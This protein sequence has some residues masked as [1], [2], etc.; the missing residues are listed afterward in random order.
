[1]KILEEIKRTITDHRSELVQKYRVK[2]IGIFGS[3]IR[4]EQNPKSDL[5]ILVEF[6]DNAV[7]GLF[8]FSSLKE[9]LCNLL[10][11]KIDLV[12]KS[13]LKP[14]MGNQILNEVVYI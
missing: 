1:M 11:V 5:D 4:D 6:E 7:I 2:E 14:H 10:G 9:E 3:Y 8:K 12:T 13:A